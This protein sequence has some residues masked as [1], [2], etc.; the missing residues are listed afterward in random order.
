MARLTSKAAGLSVHAAC[1]SWTWKFSRTTA[2]NRLS[3][4]MVMMTMKLQKKRADSVGFPQPPCTQ[5]ATKTLACSGDI[6][7][8]GQCNWQSRSTS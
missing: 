3:K 7:A 1:S 5:T 8:K 6:S 4:I 2:V